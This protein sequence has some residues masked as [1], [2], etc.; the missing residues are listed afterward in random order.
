MIKPVNLKKIAKHWNKVLEEAILICAKSDCDECPFSVD[1]TDGVFCSLGRL[2][3]AIERLNGKPNFVPN[4]VA[5]EER[6]ENNDTEH[7]P[8]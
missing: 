3:T 8:T 7:L 2:N 5:H 4:I 1:T 6:G